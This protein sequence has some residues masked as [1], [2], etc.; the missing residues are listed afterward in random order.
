MPRPETGLIAG[1]SS[2]LPSLFSVPLPPVSPDDEPF[3]RSPVHPD[4]GFHNPWSGY[5]QRGPADVF[6]W[7]A[8]QTNPFRAEKQKRAPQLPAVAHG[9]SAWD[10]IHSDAKVQWLGHASVLVS[11]DG[12]NVLIDPVFGAAGP[13][14]RRHVPPPRPPA[15]L[16]PIDV[17]VVTHGHYDHLDRNSIDAV[18]R[19][20]PEV[21]VF[22]PRGQ[23]KSLPSSA[24]NVVEGLWWEGISVRGL[25]CILTP[26]QHWHLRRPWDR[27]R[28]LWAG[29]MLRSS[30]NPSG[31][32]VSVYHTGDTGWFDGFRAIRAVLGAPD[33]AV[34]PLGAYEPR[35]FMG[36]QH[37]PPE[38]SVRAFCDLQARACV[39]MHWGTFDLSDEP[40]DHGPFTLLA[41][42]IAEAGI[43]PN[44]FFVL[45]HG[46]LVCARSL[47]SVGR[48]DFHAAQGAQSAGGH[49]A[50]TS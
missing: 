44:A 30:P 10:S 5:V 41:P 34:L 12:V 2:A 48:V 37:M 21:V 42:A 13:G 39:G 43:D 9:E 6:K 8:T 27:N 15:S 20:F 49:S 23:K 25:E 16:P 24:K 4:G 35:W 40:M 3:L 18:C 26:A 46:G 7:K 50:A 32:R 19:R 29:V 33:I 31:E 47:E 11:L 45:A 38:D 28:A 36:P 1:M 14:V 17:I 22:V